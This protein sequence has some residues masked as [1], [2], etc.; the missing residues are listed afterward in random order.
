MSRSGYY[1]DRDDQWAHI[2]W[3]GQVTS[4]IRGK[5][6]QSFLK[7]LL[8]ALDELPAKRLIK[9]AL[10]SEGEVC[11]IGALGRMRGM[12]MSRLDPED[13]EGVA[14]KFGIADQLAREIVYMNDEWWEREDGETRFLRMR[15]YV[16][17]LIRPAE[18]A[19]V[20]RWADDGGATD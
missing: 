10:E 13:S 3:R 2:K 17:S 6:G 5:R 20:D 12:D 18:P 16:K 4:A 8:R 14:C 7:D 1:D 19:A 9:N 15:R 11:A